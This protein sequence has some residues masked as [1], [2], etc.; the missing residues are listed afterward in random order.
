VLALALG[1]AQ[2]AQLAPLPPTALRHPRN[3]IFVFG[4][5]SWSRHLSVTSQHERAARMRGRSV[6]GRLG[7]RSAD[8]R[9][10]EKNGGGKVTLGSLASPARMAVDGATVFWIGPGGLYRKDR[11]EDTGSD[12]VLTGTGGLLLTWIVNRGQHCESGHNVEFYISGPTQKVGGV[13]CDDYTHTVTGLA[14]GTYG[15]TF[16]MYNLLE[17]PPVVPVGNGFDMPYNTVDLGE[18]ATN[19][20]ADISMC[21][22]TSV[23]CVDDGVCNEQDDCTCADCHEES[24]CRTTCSMATFCVPFYEG[25]ACSVCASR[26]ECAGYH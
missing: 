23:G 11:P 9:S 12:A 19:A 16:Q 6:L 5:T 2:L 13:P 10:V 18:C 24:G 4:F 25:C 3:P 8:L 7:P 1:T 17:I 15:I 20:A 14:P 26:P 22:T 21:P